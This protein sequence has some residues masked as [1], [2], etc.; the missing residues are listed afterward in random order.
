MKK[1]I[2]TFLALTLIISF[3]KAQSGPVMTFEKTEIDYGTVALGAD[4]VRIFKFKNTGTEPLVI[5][6]ARGSCGCTVPKWP[7]E[8]IGVGKTGVIEVKYDTNRSGVFTKSV[9]VETNESNSQHTLTIKGSVTEK[10]GETAGA[11]SSGSKR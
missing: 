6:N 9:Y 8:P 7:N 11:N 10:K 4:G 1:V 2:S 3:A 5:K